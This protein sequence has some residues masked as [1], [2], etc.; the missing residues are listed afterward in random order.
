MDQLTKTNKV[1]LLSS[2]LL[3]KKTRKRKIYSCRDWIY[4]Q[5]AENNRYRSHA[6]ARHIADSGY[7]L[8]A[9]LR[10]I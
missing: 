10:L 2:F 1:Q 4:S 8:R 9:M 7:T 3:D 5:K 6:I